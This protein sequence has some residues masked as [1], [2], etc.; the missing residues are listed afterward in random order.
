MKRNLLSSFLAII[1]VFYANAQKGYFDAPYKRYEA[2]IALLSNGASITTKS[3]AQTDLQSEA[4]DQTCVNMSSTDAT[5]DFTLS[6]EADGFVM[7]YSVPDGETAV[8]ALYSGS[9][10]ITSLTLTTYWSWEYLWSNGD[11]NN[12]GITNENPRKRFDEVRYKLPNSIAANGNL[13]LVKES[14]NLFIDF[15]EM[16]KVPEKVSVPDDAVVYSGDGSTLQAFI[17]ANGGK[18]IYL[19]EGIYNVDRELY[20]GFANS[21][22]QGAGMWYTQIHFTSTARYKGGLRANAENISYSDLYLTTNV[23]S[24]ITGYTSIT[25]VYTSESIIQNI[26]SEHF[27]CGAWIGQYNVGGPAFADGFLLKN[28]RFRNSYA[29]GINLCKGTANAIVEHCNFRNNGDDDQAIWSAEGMECI[30]NT[31]RYNTSEHCWRAAGLAIYG[32]KDNKAHNLIIKDNLEVG[33]RINNNFPGVEFNADGLHQFHDI[34]IISCGTF[35][36]VYNG[37]VGAIDIV[38]FSTAGNYVRNI[39]FSDINILN[40]KNDAIQISKNSGDGITNLS[41]RDITIDGT[42]KEY[43]YNNVNNLNWGRGYFVLFSRNPSGDATYCNMN[44]LNRGGNA[45]INIETYGIGTLSWTEASDCTSSYSVATSNSPID[46]G[47]VSGDGIYYEGNS[48][49]L[50]A[51]PKTGYAFVKWTENGTNI[52][53]DLSYSFPISSD[54]NLVAVYQDEATLDVVDIKSSNDIKVYPNPTKGVVNFSS[55]VNVQVTNAMGQIIKSQE[56]TKL[57]DISKQPVGVYFLNIT[58]EDGT[59]QRTKILKQ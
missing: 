25:G 30:N 18:T 39:A 26:W 35:N 29:D 19:P 6:E 17:D 51:S 13:R 38:N 31:F 53:T 4:S 24:R 41:F 55:S 22:L 56:N 28:C 3:Y 14:G 11:T 52:S 48:V 34:D 10:Y 49:T 2:D 58:K 32:G 20:F 59:I 9:T 15:I 16:E 5:L 57:I 40:S 21:K 45:G 23:N 8:V 47:L 42:G 44:Y 54:R 27:I 12:T 1:V 50:T 46:A 36:D 43:P 7:R 33:I 37:P